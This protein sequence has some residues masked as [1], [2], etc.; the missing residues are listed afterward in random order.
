M[1]NPF[2]VPDDVAARWRPLTPNEAFVAETLVADASA[3]I[4]AR[5]PGIDSQVTS[6][7][8]DP[9]VLTLVVAGMVKRALVSPSDGVASAT[10][11]A[12]P[13]SQGQ[14]F[15]NPLGNVFLT[16]ADMTLILG[17]QP[18]GASHTYANTTIRRPVSV[19]DLTSYYDGGV[20]V[21]P[22]NPGA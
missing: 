14:T 3:L 4:R 13:Y 10:Q 1:A 20:T 16:A 18:A 9:D 8:I 7:A 15:A 17:Y 22:S 11:T 5:F 6:G 21:I 2:A 19:D 12:G